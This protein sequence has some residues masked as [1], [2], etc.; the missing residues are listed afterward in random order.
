MTP[1]I[2][3]RLLS[4][5]RLYV[6]VDDTLIRHIKNRTDMGLFIIEGYEI[7]EA[8]AHA[9]LFC[10]GR[11]RNNWTANLSPF[12]PTG[13]LAELIIWSG[14]GAAWAKKALDLLDI[15]K[16]WRV[17]PTFF[18]DKDSRVPKPGDLFIDDDPLPS[19]ASAT[20]HPR[21]FE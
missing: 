12:T 8:V 18:L 16:S 11:S 1:E 13:D 19:F 7:N 20:I 5:K 17:M 9:V 4:A 3:A 6:D 21:E 10:T 14:G 2:E 15:P